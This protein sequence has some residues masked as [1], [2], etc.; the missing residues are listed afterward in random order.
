MIFE[1]SFYCDQG[2]SNDFKGDFYWNYYTTILNSNKLKQLG[3]CFI[4]Y[5]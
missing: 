2:V 4:H 3:I 5:L 1:S